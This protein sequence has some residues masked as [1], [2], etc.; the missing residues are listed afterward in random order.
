MNR[1]CF[2]LLAC[3][4]VAG[5][6]T[7]PERHASYS[8]LLEPAAEPSFEVS[9]SGEISRP[10]DVLIAAPD[11]VEASPQE[12]IVRIEARVLRVAQDAARELG[13]DAG[14]VFSLD[15]ASAGQLVSELRARGD[16][17]LVAAS[18]LSVY[19]GQTGTLTM[20]REV[21]YVSGYTIE[22][23][24]DSRIVKPVVEKL[25]DGLALNVKAQSHGDALHLNL[26][27][28][29]SE[30][31]KPISTQ[32][33]KVFNQRVM[34]Q[35]PQIY[36]QRLECAGEVTPGRT[37]M[38]GGMTSHEGEALLVLLTIARAD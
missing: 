25:H 35:A 20:L 1:I 31:L 3:V 36:R 38:L 24:D 29:L 13:L 14:G 21:S 9:Y 5:C 32:T 16:G 34:V 2:A 8:G 11:S 22:K 17:S 28:E 15:D 6:A 18:R 27:L 23:Q 19:E 30:M 26:E 12:R 4:L 10:T 33:I 7:G 37:L